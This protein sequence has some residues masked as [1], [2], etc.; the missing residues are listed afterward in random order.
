MRIQTSCVHCS[1]RGSVSSQSCK[2]C[3]GR[4]HV[5][6]SEREVEVS[7]PPGVEDGMQIRLAGE[8]PDGTDLFAVVV[9]DKHPSIERRQRNLVSSVEVH[10]S[11]LVLGGEVSFRLFDSDISLKIPPRTMAGSRFRMRGQG[12]PALQN[13]SI[14]GDL[15][16]DVKLKIP[17]EVG[18][19]QE[20]LLKKIEK[21]DSGD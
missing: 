11:K 18:A 17:R 8:G 14:R 12:M 6:K 21:L 19:E 16:L 20:S 7:I 4:G 5:V 15:F 9:V 2:S 1:G 10:Y 13:P 3:N